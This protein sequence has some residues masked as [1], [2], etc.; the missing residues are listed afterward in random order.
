MIAI[1]GFGSHVKK[2]ILPALSRM[3]VIP[4]YIVVRKLDDV[5]NINKSITFTDDFETVLNDKDVSIIYIATPIS[6]HFELAKKALLK[7]KNVICEKPLTPNPELAK[8]LYSIANKNQVGLHQV[9]MYKYH[10]Q[11][12]LLKRIINSNK[13][14]KLKY[15]VASFK[16]PHLN[17]NDIRYS[18]Q[19]NGGALLDVGF[20]PVSALAYLFPE[21]HYSGSSVASEVDYEVDLSGVATFK[22]IDTIGIASWAIG[23]CY[24]NQITLEFSKAKLIFKRAFSKPETLNTEVDVIDA[25]CDLTHIDSGCDDQFVNMFTHL[26]SNIKHSTK[27]QEINDKIIDILDK[28]ANTS[29]LST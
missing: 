20:Y 21:L 14:G 18:P 22:M 13:Y 25:F 24:E 27:E 28:I 6:T 9:A 2:N 15:V 17:E 26:F 5:Q 10:A 29:S 4:S 23:S 19:L 3:N 8:E 12:E 1:V 7:N 16:I 11:F